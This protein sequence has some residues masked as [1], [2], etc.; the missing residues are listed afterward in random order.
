MESLKKPKEAKGAISDEAIN[1]L[2][3]ITGGDVTIGALFE[4]VDQVSD[5]DRELLKPMFEHITDVESAESKKVFVRGYLLAL[6][7]KS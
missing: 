6:K 5:T 7:S 4:L 2:E 1:L 3:Q